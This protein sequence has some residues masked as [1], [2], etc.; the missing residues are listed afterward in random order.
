VVDFMVVVV[1]ET[2]VPARKAS[3]MFGISQFKEAA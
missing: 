2:A 1:A 3:S